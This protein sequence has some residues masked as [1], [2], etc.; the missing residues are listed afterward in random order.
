M[1]FKNI[2]GIFDRDYAG[3]RSPN[4]TILNTLLKDGVSKV[5]NMATL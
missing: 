1:S 2:E 3:E 4:I 5:C